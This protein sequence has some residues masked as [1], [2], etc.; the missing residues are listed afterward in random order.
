[1]IKPPV[2]RTSKNFVLKVN[3][4]KKARRALLNKYFNCIQIPD[5]KKQSKNKQHFSHL[6][7]LLSWM[8][9][10]ICF[11]IMNYTKSMIIFQRKTAY[12]AKVCLRGAFL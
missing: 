8:R 6:F 1:M 5:F 7:A 3:E 10:E 2:F 11:D 9:L 12:W 4:Q